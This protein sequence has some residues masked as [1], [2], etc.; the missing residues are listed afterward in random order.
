L[1]EPICGE[2]EMT[3][4]EC[5]FTL[6][7]QANTVREGDLQG[8]A[9]EEEMREALLE[10]INPARNEISLD[11]VPEELTVTISTQSPVSAV[12]MSERR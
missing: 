5:S 1:E 2:C 6:L 9:E 11:N 3:G 10:P 12:S 7:H 8:S 4:R